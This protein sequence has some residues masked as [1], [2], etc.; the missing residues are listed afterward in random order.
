MH[1]MGTF[2]RLGLLLAC[3]GSATGFLAPSFANPGV[4]GLTTSAALLRQ[5]IAGGVAG[6]SMQWGRIGRRGAGT[7]LDAVSVVVRSGF[8]QL[9]QLVSRQ[10]PY[11]GGMLDVRPEGLPAHGMDMDEA[12]VLCYLQRHGV[13]TSEWGTG[14]ARTPRDLA[15]EIRRGES[16]LADGKR[17][18][19][20]VKVGI[21]DGDWD[22]YESRQHILK[23]GSIKERNRCLSEKFG[24]RETPLEAARRGIREELN[25]VVGDYPVVSFR[26][27]R[28]GKGDLT[29]VAEGY[30]SSFPGLK[31]RYHFFKVDCE[32][33]GLRRDVTGTN[34]VTDEGKGRLHEW[35]WRRTPR[36][37]NQGAAT[38]EGAVAR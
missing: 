16:V 21:R 37:A 17:V 11:G 25:D 3:A 10:P 33:G 27:P 19:Y 22:L 4:K 38:R 14:L 35:E 7:A 18:I 5:P 13:D 8:S 24:P 29:F 28:G 12:E 34:F 1:R 31:T 32:V 23:N 2:L 9:L 6:A 36:S 20:V 15:K 26:E 30:S